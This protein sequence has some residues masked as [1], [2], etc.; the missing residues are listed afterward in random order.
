[1]FLDLMGL[2]FPPGAAENMLP[3]DGRMEFEFHR[4]RA[5]D[6]EAVCTQQMGR[7]EPMFCATYEF[8]MLLGSE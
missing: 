5:L 2:N 3:F 4:H 6:P 1:M 8:V 7:Y